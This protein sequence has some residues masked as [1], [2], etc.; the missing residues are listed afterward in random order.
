MSFQ[1]SPSAG[2]VE[3]PVASAARTTTGNTGLLQIRRLK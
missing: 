1:Q 3:Q 2:V